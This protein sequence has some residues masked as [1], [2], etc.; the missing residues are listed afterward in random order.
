MAFMGLIGL[1]S[2]AFWIWAL[3]DCINN[4]TDNDRI[5]WVLVII[6]VHTLGAIL[7]VIFGRN[8]RPT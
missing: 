2:V 5:L 1:A 4:K 6:F 3:V 7:Y 8:S